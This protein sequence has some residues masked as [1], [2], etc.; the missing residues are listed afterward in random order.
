MFAGI[1]LL[2]LLMAWNLGA[3]FVGSQ[4]NSA[5]LSMAIATAI[6]AVSYRTILFTSPAITPSQPPTS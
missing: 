6:A 5:S 3:G 1:A 2:A 4:R